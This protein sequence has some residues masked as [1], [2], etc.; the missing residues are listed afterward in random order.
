MHRGFFIG[1]AW[2]F[3]FAEYALPASLFR[4]GEIRAALHTFIHA[5]DDACPV[6][7]QIDDV[8]HI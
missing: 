4:H 6:W 2:L 3:G 8:G 1:G 5:D 7:F